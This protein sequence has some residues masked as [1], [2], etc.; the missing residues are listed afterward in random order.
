[1][2]FFSR[3]REQVFTCAMFL[4]KKFIS[5]SLPDTLSSL[6]DNHMPE[7]ESEKPAHKR[8]K[9]F[10]VTLE[11]KHRISD[12]GFKQIAAVYNSMVGHWGLQKCRE[13][14]KDPTITDRTIT[15]FIRQ[16]PCCQVMSRLNILI[17]T[18]PTIHSRVYT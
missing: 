16:C 12:A 8:H 15:Q 10:L 17:K 18:H 9:A 2:N 14:L 5:S 11:P 3:N 6:C 1:M 13:F 4:E 7:K